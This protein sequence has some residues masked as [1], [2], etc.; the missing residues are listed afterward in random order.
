MNLVDLRQTGGGQDGVR[1]GAKLIS[2]LGY[3]GERDGGERSQADEPAWRGAADPEHASCARI[4]R[5]WTGIIAKELAAFNELL[6]QRNV[7]N[8]IVRPRPIS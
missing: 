4:S 6:K 1:F 2:K 7:P 3:L 8:V 5:R